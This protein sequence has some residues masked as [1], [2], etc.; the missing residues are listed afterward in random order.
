M[1][2]S[3]YSC[4][5]F[6]NRT[7]EIN[8]LKNTQHINHNNNKKQHNCQMK[9]RR[10]KEKKD[11]DTQSSQ[12]VSNPSTIW[13]RRGLTSLI[14]REVV[15][16]SWCGRNQSFFLSFFSFLCVFCSK[17]KGCERKN[18]QTTTT[19]KK[20]SHTNHFHHLSQNASFK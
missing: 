16:S 10:K 17:K 1:N 13:A 19:T 6:N 9:K 5:F 12:A 20:T 14:R 7:K 11:Y 4:F 2:S 8:F 15:F 3:C 18:T